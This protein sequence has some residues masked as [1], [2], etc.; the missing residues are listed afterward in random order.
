MIKNKLKINDSKTEFK[1]F[2]YPLLKQNLSY[3]SISVGDTLAPPSSKVIDLGVV[4]TNISLFKIMLVV[5]TSLLIFTTIG[6]IWNLLTFE[7]IALLIYALITTRLDFQT[8]FFITF[9][10]TRLKDYNGH[11]TRT[12]VC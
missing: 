2:R 7:V 5:C 9:Q 1:I 12:H 8:V 3:L 10:T 11:K 4:L 6:R